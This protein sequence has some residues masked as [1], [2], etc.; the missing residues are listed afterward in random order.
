MTL[1]KDNEKHN[2][3]RFDNALSG[4]KKMLTWL[5][6]A[7]PETE[8]HFCLEATGAYGN[9]VAEFLTQSG[10]KVS[11]VNPILTHNAAKV[12]NISNRTDKSMS[13]VIAIFCKKEKPDIWRMAKPE[14]R[15][16]SALVRRR[17]PLIDHLTQE[18]IRLATPGLL[19]KIQKSIKSIIALL[20]KEIASI[21]KQMKETINQTPYL[22]EDNEFLTSVIGIGNLTSQIILAELPAV[23]ECKDGTSYPAFAGLAPF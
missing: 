6:Y 23:S 15:K 5:K 19:K 11:V 13:L 14:V 9:A 18:K 16:L 8:L 10:L 21:E 17:E 3:K 20:Q 7:A 1:L 4:F 22:K 2:Y 12:Y